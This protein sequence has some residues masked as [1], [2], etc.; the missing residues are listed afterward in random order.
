MLIVSVFKSIF[1]RKSRTILTAISVCIGV[2]SL[3]LI[4]AASDTGTELLYNELDG[5]GIGGISITNSD[6]VRELDKDDLDTIRCI[7]GVESATPLIIKNCILESRGE[8]GN[9]LGW[10]IDYGSEQII[11]IEII[12]GRLFSAEDIK[13][14]KFVCILDS[15][16]AKKI[17]GR[18][19]V[20]GETIS[21]NLNGNYMDYEIVGVAKADSNLL[22]GVVM[23]YLPYVIYFPY[24][25][26]QSET[27]SISF[28]RIAINVTDGNSTEVIGNRISSVLSPYGDGDS[29]VWE[30]LSGQR[31]RLESIVVIVKILLAVIGAVSLLVAGIGNTTAM[32]SSVK[33]RTRE[34]GIKK[35]IGASSLNITF[36]FLLESLV[37]TLLG[38]FCGVLFFSFLIG[39]AGSVLGINLIINFKTFIFVIIITSLVGILSAVYPA[40]KASKLRPVDAFNAM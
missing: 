23:D 30:D 4:T 26:L 21:V 19:A 11:S 7:S 13:K 10:G 8:S 22:G 33:E 36:E 37:V 27:G 18:E 39:I 35:S 2:L 34:I 31:E 17:F 5:M 32:I 24:S 38:C 3:F 14:C 20:I 15:E 29:V 9:A 25:T 28:N 16:T 12:D 6:G 40:V 1:R